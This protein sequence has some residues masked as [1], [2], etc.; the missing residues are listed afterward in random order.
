MA[1][2]YWV[3]DRLR[4]RMRAKEIWIRRSYLHQ[5]HALEGCEGYWGLIAT[6][7]WSGGVEGL[8]RLYGEA[9]WANH[10]GCGP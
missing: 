7:H 6:R 9:E 10:S 2:E 5:A 3:F 4:G 8:W 1:P